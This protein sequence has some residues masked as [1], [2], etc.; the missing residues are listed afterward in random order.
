[1]SN[2]SQSRARS[3]TYARMP[4]CPWHGARSAISVETGSKTTSSVVSAA[5]ASASRSLRAFRSAA[6]ICSGAVEIALAAGL[7]QEGD[8]GDL[9]ALLQ[10]LDHVVDGQRGHRG[11]GQGLHLDA[12]ARGGPR[13]GGE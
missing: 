3:R 13:L 7:L 6:T 11:G 5:T 2:S 1:M 10:P 4:A 9:H 12:G 8:P